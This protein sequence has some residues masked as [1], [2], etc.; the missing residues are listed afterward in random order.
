M[1]RALSVLVG[2]L[3]LLCVG[4]FLGNRPVSVLKSELK[5]QTEVF[6]NERADLKI[7]ATVA[8]ARGFLWVAHAELLMAVFRE[9][10]RQNSPD[11]D[12]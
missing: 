1:M 9:L 8:E 7:K 11:N 2:V 3:V 5:Q 6:A 4:W 12:P 10:K